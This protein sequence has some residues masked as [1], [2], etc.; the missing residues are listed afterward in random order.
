MK[1][2]DALRLNE[3]VWRAQRLEREQGAVGSQESVTT[4]T[5]PVTASDWL[6]APA[7][8]V[9]HAHALL[10]RT[11]QRFADAEGQTKR[12]H[13]LDWAE[14]L[15]PDLTARFDARNERQV[16]ALPE[17]LQALALVHRGLWDRTL[18]W[19]SDSGLIEQVAREVTTEPFQSG[20]LIQ[21]N[22]M[23]RE[24][25][26]GT[27][28]G[29]S[30]LWRQLGHGFMEAVAASEHSS[31][32]PLELDMIYGL[33]D[34][35]SLVAQTIAE[36]VAGS[37]DSVGANSV[38]PQM[39]V[40]VLKALRASPEAWEHARERLE[41]RHAVQA[42]TADGWDTLGALIDGW[43]N[44]FATP[45]NLRLYHAHR[46]SHPMMKGEWADFDRAHHAGELLK[47][48]HIEDAYLEAVL[49]APP[50]E[51]G[52]VFRS[53][54]AQTLG[55][56]TAVH[57]FLERTSATNV[58]VAPPS[59]GNRQALSGVLNGAL[60]LSE[61]GLRDPRVLTAMLHCIPAWDTNTIRVPEQLRA[62]TE[63]DLSS[64]ETIASAIRGNESYLVPSSIRNEF[65][66]E[67]RERVR[68][69]K[70][71]SALRLIGLVQRHH[72]YSRLPSAVREAGLVE[73]AHPTPVI[74]DAVVDVMEKAADLYSQL[75]W[76]TLSET[77]RW[78]RKNMYSLV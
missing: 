70:I 66:P 25:D 38:H 65:L 68:Q 59:D 19:N 2:T 15:V 35:T 18:N 11:G 12:G 17:P 4:P 46:V 51:L 20:Y 24:M 41:T 13:T 21:L 40:N 32:T 61:A 16:E 54:G 74:I 36:K 37:A 44:E 73:G 34:P 33:A 42:G 23:L 8:A 45:E 64:V 72:L 52:K 29:D 14:R 49:R 58:P 6:A 63:H 43:K 39:V 1:V 30:R 48:G 69:A 50:N 10:V 62:W 27:G 31:V 60:A 5:L 78:R 67:Q 76:S 47:L 3:L 7:A 55:A 28:R 56:S 26:A 53:I 22:W 71:E 9:E 57:Q 77:E 75:E